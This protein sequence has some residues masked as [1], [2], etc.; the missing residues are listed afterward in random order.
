MLTHFDKAPAPKFIETDEGYLRGRAIVSRVGVFRYRNADGTERMELRHPSD[1]LTQESLDSLKGIP[2]TMDHPPVLVD[3]ENVKALAIGYT[4]DDVQVDGNNITVNFT[5]TNA[6]A[7]TEIKAGKRE[8]SLGYRLDLLPE[9]GTYDGQDYTHRQVNVIYNHLAVV[10]KARAGAEARIHLD[11]ASVLI[12]TDHKETPM[13]VKVNLDG[14]AYDAAPEV[15]N[16]L[17]KERERADKAEAERADAERTKADMQKE[18]DGLKGKMDALKE[19]MDA[20]KEGNNDA[21]IAEAA[22]ARVSLLAKAGK[23]TNADAL[24]D[25]SPREI[26]EAAIKARHDSLD[27]SDKSDDYVAAR[28]DAAVEM[29]DAGKAKTKANAD[30]MGARADASEAPKDHR[31]DAANALADMWKKGA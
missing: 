9:A 6:D 30:K 5:I 12:E 18:Y 23:L 16:A 26:M 14:I 27:L 15:A 4:G 11:G 21:A 8:L 22:K 17:T 7:I 1:V 20:M 10:V 25:K 24:A 31:S 29:V 19:E 28:F 13:T 3:S 2:L